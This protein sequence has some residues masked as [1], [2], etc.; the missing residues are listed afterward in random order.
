MTAVVVTPLSRT[1]IDETFTLARVGLPDLTRAGW[2]SITL[3][4]L[5]HPASTAGILLA[6]DAAQRLKGL[7][8]YSLSICIAAGP[9]VQ[10]ERLISFDASNPRSVAAALVA[11]VL[12]LGSS[13]GCDSISLVRPLDSPE[14][15]SA[16]VLASDTAVLCQ[17]F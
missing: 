1:A 12:R 2:R 14:T 11:E 3:H 15:A 16:M 5:D 6:R 17:M 10:I 8:I 7:L 9:S 4:H 13:H